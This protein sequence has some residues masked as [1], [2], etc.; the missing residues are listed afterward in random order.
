MAAPKATTSSG[1]TPLLGFL[2]KNFSTISC[3]LGIRVEPPTKI[4]SSICEIE[5]PASFNASSQG[6]KQRA[7]SLSDNC[8][9]LAR[10]NLTTKCLGT[11][12]T[13]VI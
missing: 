6:F 9:N 10:L 11:P 7:K 5:Y 4:T 12:S 13:A 2:P 8:S 3:T 1:F